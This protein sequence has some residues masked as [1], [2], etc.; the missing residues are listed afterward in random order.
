MNLRERKMW[1]PTSWAGEE[2]M[3]C[4]R[5]QLFQER[6]GRALRAWL[7]SCRWEAQ[8]VKA[9][10]LLWGSARP[11]MHR[12]TLGTIQ[13]LPW[14]GMFVWETGHCLLGR[15][16][17]NKFANHRPSPRFTSVLS[18]PSDFHLS[19]SEKYADPFLK[20]SSLASPNGVLFETAYSLMKWLFKINTVVP[21][22]LSHSF[23]LHSFSFLKQM[24]SENIK[25]KI[26][27]I[28]N[29]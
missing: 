3:P 29:S 24:W 15:E 25:W 8:L 18:R 19:S 13:L 14:A 5:H 11:S 22:P 28:N 23:T 1:T 7:Y 20:N 4:T 6:K 16:L 17:R 12:Q 27:E 26:Q 9:I 21:P 10:S 2:E